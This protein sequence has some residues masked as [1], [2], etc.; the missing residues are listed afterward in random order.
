MYC[1][2]LSTH[3]D[4]HEL[5]NTRRTRTVEHAPFSTLTLRTHTRAR[6]ARRAGRASVHETEEGGCVHECALSLTLTNRITGSLAQR[7]RMIKDFKKEIEIAFRL[8]YVLH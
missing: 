2:L 3:A 6:L 7:D 4:T 1:I 8:R 5:Q